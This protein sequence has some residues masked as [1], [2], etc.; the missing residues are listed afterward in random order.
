M[1]LVLYAEIA[2]TGSAPLKG[3]KLIQAAGIMFMTDEGETLLLKRS[4]L[5]DLPGTW[6]FPGGMVEEGE[7]P[8]EAAERECEEE[9]GRIPEGVRRLWTRRIANDGDQQVDYTTFIQRIGKSFKPKLNDENSAFAWVRVF[10]MIN[11]KSMEPE[12]GPEIVR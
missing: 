7:T 3:L 4:S 9:I 1:E 12:Y 11:P 10:D 2:E 6:C 8:E 5:C